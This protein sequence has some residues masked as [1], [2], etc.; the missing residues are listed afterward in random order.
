MKAVATHGA[1]PF[2]IRLAD[3]E[4]RSGVIDVINTVAAER[5]YLHTDRYCST[6]TW[7]R[8]LSQSQDV[9]NGLLLLVATDR[10]RIIGFGRLTVDSDIERSRM[11][12]NIGLALLPAYRRCG[13]GRRLLRSLTSWAPRLGFARLNAAILAGNTASL[14]LFH[15]AGFRALQR[16]TIHLPYADGPTEEVILGLSLDVKEVA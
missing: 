5:R 15:S 10:D 13:I 3:P 6:P 7:E 14:W 16:R 9:V 12:G 11:T 8:I 4:D 1:R 2:K